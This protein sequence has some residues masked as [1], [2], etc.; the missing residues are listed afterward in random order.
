MEK[1]LGSG[2]TNHD[3]ALIKR[4]DELYTVGSQMLG[5]EILMYYEF[6]ISPEKESVPKAGLIQGRQQVFHQRTRSDNPQGDPR[7]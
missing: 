6:G 7:K 3:K 4:I 1:P 2:L 5:N